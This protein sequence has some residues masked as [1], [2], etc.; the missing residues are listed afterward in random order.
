MLVF[1]MA[2]DGFFDVKDQMG[3]IIVTTFEQRHTHTHIYKHTHTHTRHNIFL[4]AILYVP[5]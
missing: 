2:L 1:N 5:L 3:M 4:T